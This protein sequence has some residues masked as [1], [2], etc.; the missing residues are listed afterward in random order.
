M[1]NEKP[2]T[3]ITYRFQVDKDHF[4]SANPTL[5]GRDVLLI[6][7]KNPPQQFALYIKHRGGQPKRVQLEETV[8]LGMP[9]IEKFLTLPLDQTE[10]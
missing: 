8:D 7:G 1:A 10:G 6:A 2:T 3:T 9:G 5:T 4:D